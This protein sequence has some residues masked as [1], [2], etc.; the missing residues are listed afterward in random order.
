MVQGV[1]D[2]TSW[3]SLGRLPTSTHNNQCSRAQPGVVMGN[4]WAVCQLVE[5]K[6]SGGITASSRTLK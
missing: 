6:S 4:N 2:R 5:S 1:P 3:L